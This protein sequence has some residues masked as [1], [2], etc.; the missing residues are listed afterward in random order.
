MLAAALEAR[1]YFNLPQILV[2]REAITDIT[3]SLLGQLTCAINCNRSV[4]S[5]AH[6][7]SP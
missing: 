6:A 2:V 5:L 1:V 4:T 7:F 3:K